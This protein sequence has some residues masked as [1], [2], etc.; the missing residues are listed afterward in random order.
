[1][2]VPYWVVSH[3]IDDG[4]PIRHFA[5][6]RHPLENIIDMYNTSVTPRISRTAYKFI[7]QL[8]DAWCPDT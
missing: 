4:D 5:P 8:T 2:E 6:S 1:M 7:N 3:H